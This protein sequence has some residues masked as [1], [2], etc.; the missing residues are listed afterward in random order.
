MFISRKLCFRQTSC[1]I[2]FKYRP[3]LSCNMVVLLLSVNTE[4]VALAASSVFFMTFFTV[5]TVRGNFFQV[6]FVKQN[7]SLQIFKFDSLVETAFLLCVSTAFNSHVN[8]S[9]QG[10]NE[11][12]TFGYCRCRCC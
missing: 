8:I 5:V 11:V 9:T 1:I 2:T 12:K 4:L 3:S 6:I 10:Q 7:T